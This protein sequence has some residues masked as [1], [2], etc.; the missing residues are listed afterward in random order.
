MGNAVWAVSQR[1]L[2]LMGIV[3]LAPVLG[4]LAL[5]VRL[6]SPGPILYRSRRMER[7]ARFDMLKFRTM[8][9]DPTEAGPAVTVLGD[10]RITRVG[11]VLRR[12][13]LDELPQLWNVVRGEMLLVGPRPEDP[14]YADPA[15]PVHRLVFSERP[16]ITGTTALAYRDEESLLANEAMKLA[17]ASG[18]EQPTTDDIEQVYRETILPAKLAMDAEYLRTRSIWGD[19]AILGR[20]IGQVLPRTGRR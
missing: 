11:R 9:S 5:A 13:K 2:A 12:S 10:R 16:G 6:D 4:V 17:V 7:L 18:R 15:D 1:A 14:R 3:V 8:R 20:T 19:L